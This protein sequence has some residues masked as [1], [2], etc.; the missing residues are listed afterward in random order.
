MALSSADRLLIPAIG[1]LVSSALGV[2]AAVFAGTG[3]PPLTL[4][5]LVFSPVLS[6]A[7]GSYCLA[8]RR[9]ILKAEAHM[10]PAGER[11]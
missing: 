9:N 6:L 11:N 4:F 10:L 7:V 3:A 2:L 5:V 1:F 8:R